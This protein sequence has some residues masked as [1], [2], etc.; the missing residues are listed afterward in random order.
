MGGTPKPTLVRLASERGNGV[1]A[2][3]VTEVLAGDANGGGVGRAQ[4]TSTSSPTPQAGQQ[5]RKKQAVSSGVKTLLG[6]E[7]K[8]LGRNEEWW[9]SE[10]LRQGWGESIGTGLG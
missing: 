9:L 5:K 2:D 8:E 10:R 1:S 7:N 4:D 3:L 6:L